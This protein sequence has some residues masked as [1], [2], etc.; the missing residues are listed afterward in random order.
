MRRYVDLIR[1]VARPE[2]DNVFVIDLTQVSER[3]IWGQH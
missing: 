1:A 3:D 2:H